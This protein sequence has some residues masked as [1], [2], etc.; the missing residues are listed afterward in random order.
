[1]TKI[2]LSDFHYTINS[3]AFF[4]CQLF[5]VTSK[6]K[7]N[8]SEKEQLFE[9]SSASL[10]YVSF[11]YPVFKSLDLIKKEKRFQIPNRSKTLK[12]DKSSWNYN[13][14]SLESV[15][16]RFPS[17]DVTVVTNNFPCPRILNF[18]YHMVLAVDTSKIS[19]VN[20]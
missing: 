13:S 6:H 3:A 5:L 2:T 1:M 20:L 14:C 10:L 7:K 11:L 19:L 15:P 18:T 9:I 12:K 17:L 4:Q 16:P 8:N